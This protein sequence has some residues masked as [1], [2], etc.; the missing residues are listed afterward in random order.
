MKEE[1]YLPFIEKIKQIDT[2]VKEPVETLVGF[3]MKPNESNGSDWI[4]PS[5]VD[6]SRKS[7]HKRNLTNALCCSTL[8]RIYAKRNINRSFSKLIKEYLK[9]EKNKKYTLSKHI[10]S[11]FSQDGDNVKSVLEKILKPKKNNDNKLFDDD[12]I[13]SI[14][15]TLGTCECR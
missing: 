7:E 15:D 8:Q 4:F 3:V 5:W 1:E 11:Q 13:A 12:P 2:I 14:Y 10:V 6:Q 9:D